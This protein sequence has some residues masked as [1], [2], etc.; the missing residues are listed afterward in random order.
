MIDYSLVSICVLE[1]SLVDGVTVSE[2]VRGLV[3]GLYISASQELFLNL[4]FLHLLQMVLIQHHSLSGL[5]LILCM[6][7]RFGSLL[8]IYN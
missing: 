1:P 8:V 6:I 2:A 5:L 3:A 7:V 4:F